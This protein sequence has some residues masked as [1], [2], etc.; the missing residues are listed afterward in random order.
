MKTAIIGGVC[1]ALMAHS[2]GLTISDWRWWLFTLSVNVI[3]GLV[4]P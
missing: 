3:I 4:R 1:V 2:L